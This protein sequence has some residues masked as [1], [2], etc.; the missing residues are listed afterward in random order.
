MISPWKSALAK[1]GKLDVSLDDLYSTDSR[2]TPHPSLPPLILG[3]G[4]VELWVL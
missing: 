2:N 1:I 4:L 3:L